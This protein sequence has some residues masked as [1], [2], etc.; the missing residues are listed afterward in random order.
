MF[1]DQPPEAQDDLAR[2]TPLVAD[3]PPCYAEVLI[4]SV[5]VESEVFSAKTVRVML[6]FK[7]R[8]ASAAKPW[9]YTT[10]DTEKV[11]LNPEAPQ[12]AE[13][14]LRNG[15]AAAVRKSIHTGYFWH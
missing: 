2:S 8:K 15:F 3:A 9:T 5:F 7:L 10:M 6:V 11:Q 1:H 14:S 4:H 12:L 13:A